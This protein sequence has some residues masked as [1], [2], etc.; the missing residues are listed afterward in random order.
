MTNP[1]L[2]RQNAFLLEDNEVYTPLDLVSTS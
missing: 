2:T 1:C